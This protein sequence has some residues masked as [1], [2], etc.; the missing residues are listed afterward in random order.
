MITKLIQLLSNEKSVEKVSIFDVIIYFLEY[1][2]G[3]FLIFGAVLFFVFRTTDKKQAEFGAS[4]AGEF[5]VPAVLLIILFI[6]IFNW[7][8]AIFVYKDVKKFLNKGVM[9]G[10]TPLAWAA[11]VFGIPAFGLA[12]YL[13]IRRV[14]YQKQ[15]FAIKN[16]Q[17]TSATNF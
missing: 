4:A 8:V 3:I 9:I 6:I 10:N 1:I 7:V 5:F 14:N 11:Y 13:T 16:P 2:I 15:V 12:V 17:D